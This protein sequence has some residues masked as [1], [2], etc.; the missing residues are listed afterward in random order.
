MYYFFL[1]NTPALSIAELIAL[2]NAEVQHNTPEIIG[3]N[4]AD[5]T[6]FATRLGGTRKIAK[7]LTIAKP[8]QLRTVLS[9]LIS[10]TPQKNI[11][12]TDYAQTNLTTHDLYDLKSQAG[13]PIRLVSMDTK[14]HELIMLARQH[15]Y[16]LNILPN[17]G[18]TDLILAATD[19][20]FDAHDWLVRDR[21]K[22]Y[23][24]IK[25]GML[26][27][28]LARILANLAL[29][30]DSKKTLYD[31]FCGTGTLLAEA[32]L[33]GAKQ[34]LG[35]DNSPAATA[36]SLENLRWLTQEYRLAADLYSVMT[37][38]ATHPPFAQFDCI[39]TEPYMGPL[40]NENNPLP[41]SKI[42]DISRGLDKLYRGA[43]RAWHKLLPDFGRVVITLP[44]FA[45]YSKII[46]TISVD[47]LSS[48]GY[49]Y[50]LSVPYGKPGA[51]VIRNI[52]IL[53]KKPIS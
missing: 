23:R 50:I 40:L 17:P 20:I 27:P 13:R 45:V 34:V 11:A 18:S 8:G 9:T 49:N 21:S 38:D 47:T 53:E 33:T 19:W 35:S 52:T 2:T 3:I 43:F 14:E 31:P 46:P 51:T 16:E 26:P 39:A 28:K 7:Y 30:T 32:L 12:I 10:Q 4:I 24:L 42:R 6:H 29:T 36:G 25:R 1:G 44:S 22:P 37:A 15:V 5:Y 41:E 48:L